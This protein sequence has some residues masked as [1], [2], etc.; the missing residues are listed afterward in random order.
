MR[1]KLDRMIQYN[2]TSKC[3]SS[4]ITKYFDPDE[5]VEE[6]LTCSNCRDEGRVYDM[7]AE[8]AEVTELIKRCTLALTREQ[9]IQVLRGE[10]SENVSSH[11]LEDL[12]AF[13]NKV[14]MIT[15]ASS[16]LTAEWLDRGSLLI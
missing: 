4:F 3:L 2:R 5:Y 13:G 7:T 15:W 6:C 14:V 16:H 1:A 9:A 12:E 8:A 10:M 11:S